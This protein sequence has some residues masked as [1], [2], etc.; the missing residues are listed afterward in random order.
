MTAYMVLTHTVH[1]ADAF[2]REYV[3]AISPVLR[4]HGVEVIAVSLDTI[5]LEGGVNSAAVFRADSE[6]TFHAFYNDPDFEE[7]KQIRHS[8]TSDRSMVVL[9]SFTPPSDGHDRA[10]PAPGGTEH[11]RPG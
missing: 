10:T 7:P 1:D 4:K 3:P 6:E 11:H 5:P 2:S 8:M 9:P